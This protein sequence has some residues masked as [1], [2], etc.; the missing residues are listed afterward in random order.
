MDHHPA[1]ARIVAAGIRLAAHGLI[2][3]AEGNL[4]VRLAGDRIL[5]TPSGRR[6]DELTVPDLVIVGLG[7]EASPGDGASDRRPTSDLAIHR[8][9]YRA[10]PDVGAIVHAHVPA[11]MALTLAGE[12]PDPAVLPETALLLPRLPIVSFGAMGSQE[13]AARIAAAFVAPPAPGPDAALLERHGAIAV[14][15]TLDVAVDRMDLVDVLCRV[16]RDARLLAPERSPGLPEAR[17]A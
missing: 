15:D 7:P 13:L 17:G 12:L 16:W 3:G 10:R 4:S 11:A 1:A 8:A 6:K 5:V 14:G 9:V 2:A